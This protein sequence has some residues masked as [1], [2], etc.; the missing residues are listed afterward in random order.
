M[1]LGTKSKY[2]L[3]FRHVLM[4]LLASAAV[5]LF[6]MTRPEWSADMRLWRAFGD[7]AF[8]FLVV[9]LAIGPL[10]KLW[11]A[12]QRLIPWRREVGIWF[13]VLAVTHGV[14]II[15]GWARW[16][17]LRFLGYEFIPQLDRWARLEP[18][19]GL[20]NLMGI[21]ALFWVVVLFLTSSDRAVN[22]LGVS[23]WKWLH[24]SA[25]AI[26]YL[27]ALHGIYFLFIHFT[28]SFH[29]PVPDPNWFR[30]PFLALALSVPLLQIAA[31]IKEVRRQK[32][33]EWY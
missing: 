22:F 6:W 14:L 19:F 11:H 4:G 17:V 28:L 27:V 8:V 1:L 31:F 16:S 15:D 18:G 21:V 10:A 29:R 7:A 26:F 5:Y 9:A 23:S 33:K 30:F 25:Y 2:E 3:L 24:Y 32:R 20:A 13:A 12:A